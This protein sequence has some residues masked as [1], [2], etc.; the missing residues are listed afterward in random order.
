MSGRAVEGSVLLRRQGIASLAGSNPASSATRAWRKGSVSGFHPEGVSSTL[1]VRASLQRTGSSVGSSGGLLIRR[2][3][4]RPRP[5]SP[6]TRSLMAERRPFK[7]EVV[8]SS[9]SGFTTCGSGEMGTRRSAKPSSSGFDSHLSLHC[10]H[11]S[12]AR[13]LDCRSGD[14]GSIPLGSATIAST[15][16]LQRLRRLTG[17]TKF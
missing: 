1:A 9:P 14:R 17:Q 6:R 8:G 16:R 4:V 11:R 15:H 5:G 7:S 12:V 3:S 13:M 10:S 2:S